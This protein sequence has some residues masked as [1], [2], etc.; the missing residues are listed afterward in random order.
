MDIL[1]KDRLARLRNLTTI[2]GEPDL[3]TV[4]KVTTVNS[5]LS[6]KKTYDK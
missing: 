6:H 1:E 5:F 4:L 3:L 2:L